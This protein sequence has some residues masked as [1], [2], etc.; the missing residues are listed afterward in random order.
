MKRRRSG[1]P[2]RLN[3]TSKA[4]NDQEEGTSAQDDATA[5]ILIFVIACLILAILIL[6]SPDAAVLTPSQIA[7][8]PLWGP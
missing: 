6:R 1:R 5:P 2:F 8:M 7:L 4:S 3:T